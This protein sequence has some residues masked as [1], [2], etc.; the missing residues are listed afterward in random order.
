[1]T[2]ASTAR[3]SSKMK[4]ATDRICA[5]VGILENRCES[6]RPG[7]DGPTAHPWYSGLAVVNEGEPCAERVGMRATMSLA[8]DRTT[9]L[10]RRFMPRRYEIKGRMDSSFISMQIFGDGPSPL[11]TPEAPFAKWAAVQVTNH[12]RVPEGMEPWTM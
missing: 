6:V 8:G 2:I 10:W 12:D 7:S 11:V 5:S 4:A 1:M 3:A 9:E